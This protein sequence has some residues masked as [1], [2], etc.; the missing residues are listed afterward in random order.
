MTANVYFLRMPKCTHMNTHCNVKLPICN[1]INKTVAAIS[2]EPLKALIIRILE[3]LGDIL[4]FV[5]DRHRKGRLT[6]VATSTR[7]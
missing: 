3:L 5:L 2:V 6:K 4:P 7:H 1:E